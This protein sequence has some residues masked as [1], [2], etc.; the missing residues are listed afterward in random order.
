MNVC[1][2]KLTLC[3]LSLARVWS[4][5]ADQHWSSATV[6][7]TDL[8]SFL[9]PSSFPRLQLRMFGA[10]VSVE[11]RMGEL[12]LCWARHQGKRL[13]FA[14]LSSWGLFINRQIILGKTLFFKKVNCFW[15]TV[16]SQYY[17]SFYCSQVNQLY[18]YIYPPL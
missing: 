16:A 18:A 14:L 4:L 17:V 8:G 9:P 1:H 2:L 5:P 10:N 7:S 12:L 6:S 3:S 11:M 13:G 15:S